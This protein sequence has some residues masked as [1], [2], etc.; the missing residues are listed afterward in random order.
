MKTSSIVLLFLTST[1][2]LPLG[3]S[4]AH[5]TDQPTV[6]NQ[7]NSTLTNIGQ[8]ISDF[9]HTAN[10]LFQQERAENIEAIKEC[11]MK[12]QNATSVNRTQIADECHATIKTI[13]EKYKE[14]RKQFQDIFK[15]FRDMIIMLRHD[16]KDVHSSNLDEK[17]MGKNSTKHEELKIAL[18]HKKRMGENGT[19]SIERALKHLNKTSDENE[20]NESSFIHPHFN[21]T[22]HGPQTEQDEHD[23]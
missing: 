6:T 23:K 11:H 16:G 18:E 17:E 19:A 4:G 14:E 5:A 22:S 7:T 13:K 1:L 15:Q 12:M 3:F 8:Q 2:V 10:T 21:S 9:I 20:E